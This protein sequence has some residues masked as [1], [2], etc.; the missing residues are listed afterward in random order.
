MGASLA[1]FRKRWLVWSVSPSR[2]TIRCVGGWASIAS[3]TCGSASCWPLVDSSVTIGWRSAAA[4][5]RARDGCSR[6][7]PQPQSEAVS[8]EGPTSSITR[9]NN[10]GSMNAGARVSSPRPVGQTG[11]RSEHTLVSSN[12]MCSGMLHGAARRNRRL[13]PARARFARRAADRCCE[14]E[15]H[16]VVREV[17]PSK[18]RQAPRHQ[19]R[20]RQRPHALPRG[21]AVPLRCG[22]RAAAHACTIA[23]RV[24]QLPDDQQRGQGRRIP[25]APHEPDDSGQQPRVEAQFHGGGAG[26]PRQARAH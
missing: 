10:A 8:R 9:S 17:V 23:C 3:I 20:S 16:P 12:C 26:A 22:A 6:G 11:Q 2:A 15:G 21:H 1:P 4:R 18:G 25:A 14:P 19:R 24:R 7:S 5:I 13:R